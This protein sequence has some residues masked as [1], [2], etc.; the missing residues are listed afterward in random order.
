[1]LLDVLSTIAADK[2]VAPVCIQ[3]IGNG[4]LQPESPVVNIKLVDVLGNPVSPAISSVLATVTAKSDNSVL[5]SK[6]TLTAMSSDKTVHALDLTSPKP[7]RGIYVVDIIADTYKQKLNVK[8]LGKVKVQSLEVGVGEADS[9]SAVQKQ[10]VT[11]PNKLSTPLHA[12]QQQ[13][14]LLKTVLVDEANNKPITVHQAFILLQNQETKDEIIFVAEQDTT[15]SYK[16]DLDVGARGSDFGHR[17]GLYSLTLIVGDASLSNSFKWHVANVELKF[18]Q[19]AAQGKF[20]VFI[21]KK[22]SCF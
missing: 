19:E 10:T 6:T 7:G 18:S 14:M 22:N 3:V 11:F 20:L 17:T 8:V 1:M 12:D 15:K 4:Q 5:V 9:T 13:K 21:E 2:T 16:F